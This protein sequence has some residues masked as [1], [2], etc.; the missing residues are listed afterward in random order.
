M[1][2][3]QQLGKAAAAQGQRPEPVLEPACR[4]G[5]GPLVTSLSSRGEHDSKTRPDPVWQKKFERRKNLY[6]TGRSKS[7][8]A[9]SWDDE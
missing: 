1:R 8:P 6:F 3:S 7:L 9:Q 2:K 4:S 5:R